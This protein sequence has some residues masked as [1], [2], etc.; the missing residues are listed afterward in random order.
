[1]Q[2]HE[3]VALALYLLPLKGEASRGGPVSINGVHAADWTDDA[4]R[5]K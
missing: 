5:C 4:A 1:M 3:R 2:P